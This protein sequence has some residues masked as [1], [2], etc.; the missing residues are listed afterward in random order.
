MTKKE[1][2]QII[3]HS[4]RNDTFIILNGIIFKNLS[5]EDIVKD[6]EEHREEYGIK[7]DTIITKKTTIDKYIKLYRV[8]EDT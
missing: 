1:W 5:Y 4:I 2:E 3:G 6:I 8:E 7:H